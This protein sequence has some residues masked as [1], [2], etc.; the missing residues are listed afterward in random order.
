MLWAMDGAMAFS[1]TAGVVN[2]YTLGGRIPEIIVMGVG[3]PSEEGMA[4]LGKRTFD[5]RAA[6]L[7]VTPCW[8]GRAP[9]TGLSSESGTN[10]LTSELEAAY[11]EDHDDLEARVVREP[12]GP[13]HD[14][15][16]GPTCRPR[17]H[18]QH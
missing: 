6:R 11:A 16:H 4:G 1:L 13:P 17:P 14:S 15:G 7:P 2:L 8:P 18:L 10:G 12:P 3:Y 9:S 5:P